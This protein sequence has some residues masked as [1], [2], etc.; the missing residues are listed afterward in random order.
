MSTCQEAAD[1]FITRM[2]FVA[3][4]FQDVIL[5]GRQAPSIAFGGLI[6]MHC[7]LFYM[8]YRFVS[9]DFTRAV[10][11]FA[12]LEQIQKTHQENETDRL[13]QEIRGCTDSSHV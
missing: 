6:Y 5:P 3:R 12:S 8:A 2:R 13:Y 4:L 1:S 11:R 10:T 9:R 7:I